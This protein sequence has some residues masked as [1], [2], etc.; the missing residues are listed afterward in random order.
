M[1]HKPSG[2]GEVAGIVIP[3]PTQTWIVTAVILITLSGCGPK[4]AEITLGTIDADKLLY[5]RGTAALE[6]GDWVRA[7]E[8]F[9]EIRDNYPQSPLRADARLGVGDSFLGQ[10]QIEG[11]F[12]AKAE[13]EEFLSLFPTNPRMDYARFKLGMVHFKQMRGPE[14]DQSSTRE[15]IREFEDLIQRHPDSDLVS[16]ARE[17]LRQARDRVSESEYLVGTF[18]YR[19]KWWPGAIERFRF[20]LDTDPAFSGR[21]RLY[22]YLGSALRREGEDLGRAE[23]L[24]R[25]AA[26]QFQSKAAQEARTQALDEATE[27]L[28]KRIAAQE[29]ALL[30][31]ERLVDEFPEAEFAPAAATAVRELRTE[32]AAQAENPNLADPANDKSNQSSNTSPQGE[33]T[34]AH[35]L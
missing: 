10:G 15:A 13:F 35:P 14:L 16:Q 4:E 18:Y 1:A 27:A 9:V 12:S 29:E 25:H 21:D 30:F 8:Y 33:S 20:I 26:A 31:L 7:R 19:R 34:A 11:Y 17:F 6:E 22:Y 28:N 23:E 24:A 32:L 5:A 3:H 2:I